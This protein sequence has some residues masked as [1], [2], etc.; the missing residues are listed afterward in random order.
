MTLPPCAALAGLVTL[1]LAACAVPRAAHA[2]HDRCRY[3]ANGRWY[4]C[5]VEGARRGDDRA[6]ARERQ[7]EQ[8]R[9][10]AAARRR[11]AASSSYGEAFVPRRQLSLQVGALRYDA[12]GRETIPA[13]ALR[14]DFRLTRLLRSELGASYGFGDLPRVTPAT[15]PGLAPSP[16]LASS[17]VRAHALSATLGVLGELPTPV[18]RPYAGVAAGLFGRFDERGGERFVRPTLAVP[19]GVRAYVSPR[20]ALRGEARFRFDQLPGGPSATNTEFTAGLS[21]GY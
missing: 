14:G 7:R 21:V 6:R 20:L 17:R 4:T 1:T 5:Q 16:A 10:R 15:V 19:V 18:V 3:Y 2:Q 9:A 12:N 13:A 8:E 11:D